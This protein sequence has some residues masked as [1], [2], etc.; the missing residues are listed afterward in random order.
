MRTKEIYESSDFSSR[1]TETRKR[2]IIADSVLSLAFNE[3]ENI[4]HPKQQ[5]NFEK[6]RKGYVHCP[7]LSLS[8]FANTYY[9]IKYNT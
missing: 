4:P 3:D 1:M 7:V 2:C 8:F 5:K 6:R 9:I